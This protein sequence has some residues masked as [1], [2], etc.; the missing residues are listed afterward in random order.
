MG[1]DRDGNIVWLEQVRKCL[2]IMK[3]SGDVQV[4]DLSFI[5]EDQIMN[6][7]LTDNSMWVAVG[8]GSYVES[9]IHEY[10]LT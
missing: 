7:Q 10:Q 1:V 5:K 2:K 6:V 4:V 9:S 3:T 8:I